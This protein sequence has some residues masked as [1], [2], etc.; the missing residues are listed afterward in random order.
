[1]SRRIEPE[2]DLTGPPTDPGVS[3]QHAVLKVQPDGSWSVFDDGSPNGLQVNGRDVPS[4]SA[5]QLRDG[6]RIHL[7]AWTMITIVRD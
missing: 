6:D 7:G 1:V 4:G 3:R 5:V 2:I